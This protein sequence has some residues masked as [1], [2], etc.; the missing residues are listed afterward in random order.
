MDALLRGDSPADRGAQA[1]TRLLTLVGEMTEERGCTLTWTGNG[2]HVS[3]HCSLT[4]L[5]RLDLDWVTD[6]VA[7]WE[8][9]PP[10]A[11]LPA[12]YT[13]WEARPVIQLPQSTETCETAPLLT[14]TAAPTGYSVWPEARM[15]DGMNLLAALQGDDAIYRVHLRGV[16]PLEQDML[17]QATSRS[18]MFRNPSEGRSWL[19]R[20]V[21]VRALLA[22]P[23]HRAGLRSRA[24]VRALGVGLDL[25]EASDTDAT[26]A[27]SGTIAALQGHAQP[28][29]VAQIL[30]RFP[31]AGATARVVGLRTIDRPAVPVPVT[32]TT[33]LTAP[34]C[35]TIRLGLGVDA[36]GVPVNVAIGA[37]DLLRHLHITGASGTGKTSFLTGVAISAL[38][39]GYGCTVISPHPD[40]ARR[41]AA[42]I[43]PCDVGRARMVCSG[44]A[45]H[46]IPLN[47]LATGSEASLETI[48]SVLQAI[49]DPRHEG[50]FGHRARRLLKQGYTTARS[51]FGDRAN[52]AVI[53]LIFADRQRVHTIATA[54]KDTDP[55]TANE[56]ST[57]ISRLSDQEY[58]EL[59]GWFQSRLQTVVGTA[60]MRQILGNGADTV[61]VTT[62][63]DQRQALLID[64]SSTTLGSDSA[65]LLGELWLAKHWDALTARSDHH[66]HLIIIDE[67]HLFGAGLLPRLLAEARKFGVGIILA[68]QHLGQLDGWLREAAIANAS[69][70]LAFRSGPTEAILSGQRL[71]GWPGESLTRLP[72]LTAAATLSL[73]ST[74]TAPFSLVVDHNTQTTP[75]NEQA[76]EIWSTSRR[77]LVP[78]H[79]TGPLTHDD[80]QRALD[81][82]RA[83]TQ[84]RHR[85][86]TLVDDWLAQRKTPRT[87]VGADSPSQ[88]D[89]KLT[90]PFTG[91]AP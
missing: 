16:T 37:D 6:T 87:T 54:I 14:T 61:N 59:M 60:T 80:L 86:N 55:A 1:A 90:Q 29:G 42:E 46:P 8:A 53:P 25:V 51:L 74:Q 63:M 67:A 77:C 28:L 24:A 84:Q 57:E 68:H 9:A 48:V 47:P 31:V 11:K 21:R 88:H 20:A 43:H 75:N 66:P 5:D 13:V 69:S 73:A 91:D 32:H 15:T 7:C 71:G 18:W 62:V 2:S 45:L 64:L 22:L 56:L 83:S 52:L 19:G 35:G 36:A 49:L 65:R 79:S 33:A 82:R 3:V 44:D 70:A 30:T 41:I 38:R 17:T 72:N 58:G 89:E 40:L 78:A 27:W 26:A 81:A 34:T 39:A 23:A 12:G 76:E 85:T 50:M 10:P 4:G